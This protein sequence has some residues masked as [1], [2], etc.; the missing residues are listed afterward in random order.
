MVYPANNGP[1]PSLRLKAFYHGLQ[2]L[3]AAKLLEQKIGKD[4]V[5]QII[6]KD[7][8][9]T[10][11][12]FPHTPDHLLSVRQIINQKLKECIW[13]IKTQQGDALLRFWMFFYHKPNSLS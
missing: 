7:G 10:F 1:I 12:E 9:V 11:N 3:M 5:M 4:A 13:H 2:D 8:A 6:E